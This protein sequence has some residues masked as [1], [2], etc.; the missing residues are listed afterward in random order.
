MLMLYVYTF[1][2]S[3]I[4]IFFSILYKRNFI[5]KKNYEIIVSNIIFSVTKVRQISFIFGFNIT[6]MLLLV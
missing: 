1:C 6:H 2:Q 4:C 5:K 3:C